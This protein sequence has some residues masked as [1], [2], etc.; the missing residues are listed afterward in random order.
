LFAYYPSTDPQAYLA[1]LEKIAVLAVKKVFPAHH[2]LD[3]QP[4]ILSRMRD[5]FLQLKV[6]GNL[7]HGGGTFD[8]GDWV[9]WL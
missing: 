8:Y 3:I 1:S 2:S 5:A 6:D 7:H 9:V 4:E